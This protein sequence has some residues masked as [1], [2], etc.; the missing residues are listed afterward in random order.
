MAKANVK[1]REPDTDDAHSIEEAEADNLAGD[2][3]RHIAIE[4]TAA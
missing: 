3:S 1:E 4:C 2:E